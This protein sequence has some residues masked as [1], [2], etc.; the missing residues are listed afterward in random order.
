MPEQSGGHPR[1]GG[2]ASNWQSAY[3]CDKLLTAGDVVILR[4]NFLATLVVLAV[5]LA[6]C[7]GDEDSS[8]GSGPVTGATGSAQAPATPQ[9]KPRPRGGSTGGAKAPAKDSSAAG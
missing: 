9:E 5:A 4:G 1:S 7:G 3:L 6:A 8:K 2:G